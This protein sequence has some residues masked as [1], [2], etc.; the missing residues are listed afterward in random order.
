MFVL[1]FLSALTQVWLYESTIW[2]EVMAAIDA[3]GLVSLLPPEHP[4]S[5]LCL[6]VNQQC[7]HPACGQ[8]YRRAR[9]KPAL[10]WWAE[11]VRWTGWRE[12]QK[13]QESF[14]LSSSQPGPSEG[15]LFKGR[16]FSLSACQWASREREALFSSSSPTKRNN[17]SL[18]CTAAAK[19]ATGRLLTITCMINQVWMLHSFCICAS[20]RGG[21]KVMKRRKYI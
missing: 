2:S 6:P 19:L 20:H 11:R 17:C 9:A 21:S 1:A 16:D 8:L 3:C 5:C 13:E 15:N 7:E 18:L 12:S 14:S 10:R 4:W